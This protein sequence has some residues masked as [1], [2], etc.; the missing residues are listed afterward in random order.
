MADQNKR[1]LS[2]ILWDW[3]WFIKFISLLH[4]FATVPVWFAPSISFIFY[5]LS[6]GDDDES[7]VNYRLTEVS[8]IVYI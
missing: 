6:I 7:Y 3:K 8:Q 5:S 4:L 1:Y 2:N